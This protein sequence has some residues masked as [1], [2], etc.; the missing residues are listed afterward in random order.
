MKRWIIRGVVAIALTALHSFLF[1]APGIAVAPAQIVIVLASSFVVVTV[2]DLIL[3][4]A[5]RRARNRGAVV[6][7]ICGIV[8]M[9]LALSWW[10]A[11]PAV[12]V[13]MIGLIAGIR[14]L[15]RES[16][17]HERHQR[18][19]IAGLVLNALAPSVFIFQVVITLVY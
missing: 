15:R 6:S 13:A 10:F 16:A 2:L 18:L 17:N 1:H 19:N 8:S 14:T 4:W 9:L 5:K 11:F 7:F 12:F 3:A